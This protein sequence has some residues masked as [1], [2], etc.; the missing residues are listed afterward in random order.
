M[1][2][3]FLKALYTFCSLPKNLIPKVYS[4]SEQNLKIRVMNIF[5][6]G[7]NNQFEA[8]LFHEK[9]FGLYKTPRIYRL[10]PKSVF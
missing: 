10:S 6:V 5:C 7:A 3:S 9:K 2:I 8:N 1:Q 4:A